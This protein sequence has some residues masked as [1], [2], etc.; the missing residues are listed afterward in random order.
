MNDFLYLLDRLEEVLGSGS[1]VPFTTRTM[2]DENECLD[3]LD[4][5][6][7]ALP[8]EIQEAQQIERQRDDLLTQARTEANRILQSAQD[9]VD[10]RI[11][12][13]GLVREAE[14]RAGQIEEE[15]HHES[16]EI[17]READLY[18]YRTLER[19][20]GH[21]DNLGQSI[22]RS[23]QQLAPEEEPNHLVARD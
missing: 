8:E 22:D 4:Q 14:A 1:K 11:S 13:H 6:R 19:L 15:A 2:V 16:D 7:L 21:V 10:A 9:Q 18:A 23:L 12:E 3:I 20:R 17:R 5:I